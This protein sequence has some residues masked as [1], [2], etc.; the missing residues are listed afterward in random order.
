MGVARRLV[1][2]PLAHPNDLIPGRA[3]PPSAD[4][5]GSTRVRP[6]STRSGSCRA[7]AGARP[8]PHAVRLPASSSSGAPM[9]GIRSDHR[10]RSQRRR[11]G[12]ARDTGASACS[13][14][15]RAVNHVATAASDAQEHGEQQHLES[16]ALGISA[17]A[18]LLD[19]RVVLHEQRGRDLAERPRWRRLRAVSGA[20]PERE[21]PRGRA[22]PRAAHR[23]RTTGRARARR[24]GRAAPATT[25]RRPRVGS[26]ARRTASTPRSPRARRSRSN[27]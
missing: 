16:L 9:T 20:A 26:P 8:P 15:R 24:A 3:R 14:S 17:P 27:T 10:Q 1:D 13:R 5:R 7:I 18:E 22:R 12:R 21:V 19:R 6:A 2:R 25:R 11:G 4:G 23:G